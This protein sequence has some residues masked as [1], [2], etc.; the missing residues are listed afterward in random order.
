MHGS[1]ITASAPL[2]CQLSLLQEE[3][4]S[5]YLIE[6]ERREAESESSEEDEER[7]AVRVPI[8]VMTFTHYHC[9]VDVTTY[10]LNCS[11]IN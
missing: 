4:Y 2:Q 8:S 5:D 10:C 7:E 3:E 11:L 1:S 6:L 9:C